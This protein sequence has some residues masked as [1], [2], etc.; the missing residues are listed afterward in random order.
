MTALSHG[1]FSGGRSGAPAE[2]DHERRARSALD[3]SGGVSTLAQVR[4]TSLYDLV[5]VILVVWV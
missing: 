1:F 5:K 2:E 3:I 4:G